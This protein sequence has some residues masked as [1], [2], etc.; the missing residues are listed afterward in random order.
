MPLMNKNLHRHKSG[1]SLVEVAIVLF[2]MGIFV[3]F[4]SS[5]MKNIALSTKLRDARDR[6]TTVSDSVQAWAVKNRVIP[7][8]PDIGNPVDYWN[9]QYTLYSY[10]P[11]TPATDSICRQSSTNLA[12]CPGTNTAADCS[13]SIIKD[14]AYMIVSNGDNSALEVL[15][16]ISNCPAGLTCMPKYEVSSGY[17]DL[18]KYVTLQELKKAVGCV[19]ADSRLRILNGE[20]PSAKVGES[21][22]AVIQADG[23]APFNS[24][25]PYTYKWCVK[26]ILPAGLIATNTCPTYS[27]PVSSFLIATAGSSPTIANAP[28]GVVVTIS[29]KDADTNSAPVDKNFLMIVNP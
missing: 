26:G 8:L 2:F 20:L 28:T 16:V 24:A 9:K 13:V 25:P 15:P 11:V 19:E 14:I 7:S 1:F 12:I 17:D 21:Y 10:T 22:S 3:S 5:M 27:T 4:A 6:M 23:G 29:V 18:Y